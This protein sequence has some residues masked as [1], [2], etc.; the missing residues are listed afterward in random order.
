MN[1]RQAIQ[2]AR[3]RF[4]PLAFVTDKEEEQQF[5]DH[6]CVL[7]ECADGRTYHTMAQG[8]DYL[9]A[10]IDADNHSDGRSNYCQHC[11]WKIR[12]I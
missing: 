10:L 2:A 11:D 7:G 5:F 4:G 1:L 3:E 12:R 9:E 6:V 8:L